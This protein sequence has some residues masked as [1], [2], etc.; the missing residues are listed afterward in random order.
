LTNHTGV[1][2]VVSPIDISSRILGPSNNEIEFAKA[3]SVFGKTYLVVGIAAANLKSKSTHV[4]RLLGQFP[5][6]L[7]VIVLPILARKYLSLIGELLFSTEACLVLMF[8]HMRFGI[9]KV[10]VRGNCEAAILSFM[11][12]LMGLPLIYRA[13]ST[14]I[15]A[16]ELGVF[17]Y[18][19]PVQM[20]LMRVMRFFDL[21]ALTRADV[22]FT[23]SPS[24]K[25]LILSEVSVDKEKIVLMPY[26]IPDFF[27]SKRFSER[28]PLETDLRKIALT[29]VGSLNEF[30]DFD[31]LISAIWGLK[32]LG[33]KVELD[34]YGDGPMLES[35]S[36]RA[37]KLD[38]QGEIRI[39][40]SIPRK[41]VPL[42]QRSATAT[43]IP[44]SNRLQRGVS[45][46]SI[47]A[48]AMGVPVIVSKR[49][50]SIYVDGENCIVLQDNST[51]SWKC[52]IRD[53]LNSDLRHK[54]I[55]G[56]FETADMFNRVRLLATLKSQ[57][58]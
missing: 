26:F 40:S 39:H 50:D 10:I 20:L 34:I 33:Y 18:P 4:I 15:S 23:S 16:Y 30:Y 37:A 44:Y 48:M 31:P 51:E 53:L 8:L 36:N 28:E 24:A 49:T 56:G 43:L 12:H 38:L 13:I 25:D 45:L 22:I 2:L 32:N 11:S 27:F 1:F 58:A 29:Y 21:V 54:L 42:I 57:I 46:K 6:N 17:Q 9:R 7:S 35:V 14:P 3:V 5:S 47:E 52:A 55:V 41:R 19:K